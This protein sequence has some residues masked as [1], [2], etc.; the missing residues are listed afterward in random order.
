MWSWKLRVDPM[1]CMLW[2]LVG[3]LLVMALAGAA[4]FAMRAK[5]PPN[6]YC[7]DAAVVAGET[8][9]SYRE[10]ITPVP[11]GQAAR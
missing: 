4:E 2:A 9:I 6:A 8:V 10:C 11:G 7:R 5:L 3:L 1:G